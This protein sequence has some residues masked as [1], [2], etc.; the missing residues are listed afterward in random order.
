MKI[1]LHRHFLP[2]LLL[3]L[4]SALPASLSASGHE[5]ALGIGGGF[6]SYNHSGYAKMYFQYT[7]AP[8]LRIAPEIGYIFP[9]KSTSGFEASVDMQFPFRIARGFKFYPLAGVTIN[10]WTY[11][12]NGHDT[13]AGFNLGGGFDLYF[14]SS[15]K[16]SIEAKYALVKDTDGLF[17]DLGF[18]YV[19]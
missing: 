17:L 19:F 16:L 12:H 18:G 9:N 1:N 7:F 8:M 3:C 10:N 15:F 13:R 6:A 2:S 11:R 5:K 14:T 4:M